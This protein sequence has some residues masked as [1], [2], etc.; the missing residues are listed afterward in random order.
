MLCGS[1]QGGHGRPIREGEV[2]TKTSSVPGGFQHCK[3]KRASLDATPSKCMSPP[4]QHSVR[5][6]P[7]TSDLENRFTDSS[8]TFSYHSPKCISTLK[9]IFFIQTTGQQSMANRQDSTVSVTFTFEP[10]A[11]KSLIGSWPNYIRYFV[12]VLLQVPSMLQELRPLEGAPQRKRKKKEGVGKWQDGEREWR[13]NC[14][15]KLILWK[16]D[17]SKLLAQ[18][19][20]P[21]LRPPQV[22]N[23]SFVHFHYSSMPSCFSFLIEQAQN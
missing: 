22:S 16:V 18:H 14:N 10:M 3:Y 6:W 1:E 15:P 11:F 5:S 8:P 21:H 19:F 23:H 13:D 17:G 12:Q 2:R 9:C 4:L 7:L 20:R